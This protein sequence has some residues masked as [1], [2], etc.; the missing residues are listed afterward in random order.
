MF[1]WL[2]DMPVLVLYSSACTHAR[3][4]TCTH[5][6]SHTHLYTR[7]RTHMHALCRTENQTQIVGHV[8]LPHVCSDFSTKA[9]STSARGFG[10]HHAST[11]PLVA[12]FLLLERLCTTRLRIEHLC[13]LCACVCVCE[14]VCV[15]ARV[16]MSVY[17]CMYV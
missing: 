6:P 16:C 1:S 14:V 5:A 11:Y 17:M 4:H 15:R 9:W 8:D 3:T 7:A 2:I 10:P 13:H 12:R